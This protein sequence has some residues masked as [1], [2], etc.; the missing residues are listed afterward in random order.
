VELQEFFVYLLLKEVI[1]LKLIGEIYISYIYKQ[2]AEILTN[3]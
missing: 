1:G 3:R 2:T